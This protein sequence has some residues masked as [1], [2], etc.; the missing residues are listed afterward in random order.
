MSLARHAL[1]LIASAA[2]LLATLWALL[3]FIQM[4]TELE[5]W[6]WSARALFGLSVF[7]LAITVAE[8][9]TDKARALRRLGDV[10]R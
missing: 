5:L 10:R 3:S 1:G 8:G 2:A 9:I 6:H 7:L 4:E